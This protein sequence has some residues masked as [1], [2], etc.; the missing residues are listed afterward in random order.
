MDKIGLLIVDDHSLFRDGLRAVLERQE[1]LVVLGEAGD[2]PNAVVMAGQVK[3]DVVLMDLHLPSGS[4][5]DATREILRLVPHCR[6][7]VLSMYHDDDLVD[8]AL[9]AGASGYL[10][11]ESR[12]S[13]VVQAIRTV[14]SGGSVF[15]PA[16]GAQLL[17]LYRRSDATHPAPSGEN[18][19]GASGGPA[20]YHLTEREL[21]VV[22]LLT[23]GAPNREIARK[24]YLSE[25]TV[26]NLLSN[27]YRKLGVENRTEAVMVAVDRKLVRRHP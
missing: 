26:K 17:S 23:A 8:R 10:L 4:G 21:Q 18:E 15:T 20:M 24:L 27:L 13:D 22:E 2:S 19:G 6:V 5:I 11:K 16:V 3:P 7:I 1:G 12:A 14:A 25:Q 9:R